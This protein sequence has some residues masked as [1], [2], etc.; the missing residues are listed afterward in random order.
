MEKMDKWEE[1]VENAYCISIKMMVIYVP[2]VVMID[3]FKNVRVTK[4]HLDNVKHRLACNTSIPDA[5]KVVPTIDDSLLKDFLV[6][7]GRIYKIN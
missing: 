7:R 6:S 3:S 2:F 5:V 4:Y 1:T